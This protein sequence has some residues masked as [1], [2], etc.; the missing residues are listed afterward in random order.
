MRRK[1]MALAGASVAAAVGGLWLAVPTDRIATIAAAELQRLTGRNF[2]I[3]DVGARLWPAPGVVLQGVV[4][5][6]PGGTL[7]TADR[8]VLTVGAGALFGGEVSITAVDVSGLH[9]IAGRDSNGRSLWTLARGTEG[10]AVQSSLQL[11]QVTVRDSSFDWADT[12]AGRSVLVT[13]IEA[14]LARGMVEAQAVVNGQPVQLVAEA[15]DAEGLWGTG[16]AARG[17]FDAGD[18]QVLFD[19]RAGGSPL[20]AEGQVTVDAADLAALAALAGA[21]VPDLPAGL[22]R[23][24]RQA[25]GHLTLTPQGSWHL[26]DTTVALD[27]NRLS[28]AADLA[29]DG[30]RPRLTAQVEGEELDMVLDGARPS[31]PVAAMLGATDATLGLRLGAVTLDG[32][33]LGPLRAEARVDRA[34]AE[35]AVREAGLFGGRLVGD[36]VVNARGGLS[37][38]G[39]LA[40]ASVDLAA[41]ASAL[42][43]AD[44]LAGRADA[45]LTFASKGE[46]ATELLAGLDG[47]GRLGIGSATL[48]GTD[49]AALFRR[50][51]AGQA[52][53]STHIDLATASVTLQDGILST[54]DLRVEAAEV[55]LAGT[56][57]L[58]LAAQTIDLQV[59]PVRLAGSDPV[60]ALVPLRV[61]GTWA[62]PG[63][64]FDLSVL[65]ERELAAERERNDWPQPV[66]VVPL[67]GTR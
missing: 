52:Q 1:V 25:K 65:A 3:G 21:P 8:V 11:R 13:A 42:G 60:P 35:V 61:A 37:V 54:G 44:R 50:A 28:V 48:Q 31:I 47:S 24:L 39:D 46:T 7:A 12:Q 10:G 38:S 4:V 45:R 55:A 27:G 5:D 51:D 22:G 64:A 67:S 23:D 26:R 29:F 63:I 41:A 20:F 36:F 34:R 57:T 17:Q 62:A 32:R 16:S 19:G 14:R 33:P 56:A 15:E 58:G 2:V 9:A 18:V 30:P 40:V 49:L 53:G 59:T 66:D 6:G 43:W